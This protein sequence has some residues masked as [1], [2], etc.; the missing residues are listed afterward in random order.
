[1]GEGRKKSQ[2]YIDSIGQGRVWS[3]REALKN[4]LVDR[5]GNI[6]DAINS[7]A[8]KAGLSEY[9]IVD[10]PTLKDPLSF[11]LNHS[12]DKLE[13]YFIKRKMG[14]SYQYYQQLQSVITNMGIQSRMPYE[15]VIN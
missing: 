11:L 10:Y 6:Q 14:E 15:I 8:K 3:G 12:T 2:S 1:M 4:G 7:A 13:N 5:L 9:K